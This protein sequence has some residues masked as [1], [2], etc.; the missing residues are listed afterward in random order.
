MKYAFS[1]LSLYVSDIES[2]KAFYTEFLGMKI[3]PEFS[4]PSFVYLQPVEG[5]PIGLQDM[6]TLPAEIPAQG[7]G[8]EVNLEVEDLDQALQEWKAK[9]IEILVEITDMGAGRYFRARVAKSHVL[10]VFQYYPEVKAM[11]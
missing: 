10:C 1:M 7:G 4:G 5:T 9:G 2:A 3:V 8:Y 6:T 11:M